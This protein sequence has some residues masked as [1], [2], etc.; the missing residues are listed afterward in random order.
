MVKYSNHP[1]IPKSTFSQDCIVTNVNEVYVK[2]DCERSLQRDLDSFFQ[3]EVPGA[4]F[5]PSVRN[6]LWNGIIHLYSIET[7]HI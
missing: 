7:G 5:M 2:V 1:A 4:R 3:F 6:R